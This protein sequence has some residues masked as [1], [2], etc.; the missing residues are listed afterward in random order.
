MKRSLFLLFLLFTISCDKVLLGDE[1]QVISL[2][3][4]LK[5]PPAL[6][7]DWEVSTLAAQSIDS[8]PIQNLIRFIQN[9]PR[10]I[11]SLL[12]FR[13]NKLVSESYFYGWHRERLHASRSASKSFI[14]TLVGI[15]IDQGHI[16][17]V[18]QKVFD[19]FPEYANLNN[20]QKSSI[21]IRHLLTMTAGLQWD[22]RNYLSD[23]PRNDETAFEKSSDRLGYI[24]GKAVVNTPGQR[25]EYNSGWPV[26]EAAIIKKSTG[27]DAEVFA[28]ENFF[29]PLNITNY[30]WRKNADDGH[31]TAIG[32]I[33]L[34]PRD[35]GKLGQLFLDNGKWKGRQIV[36]AQWVADATATVTG[37]ESNATG[38]GYHWWTATYTVDGNPVRTFRAQGSGGQ[39]IFVVPDLN[40][41]VV[42]TGGNYPPLN[43]G[44]PFNMMTNVILPAMF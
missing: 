23:D 11:H 30:Y 13:N 12:I 43:Q 36:S 26:V 31:I 41:V 27:E 16:S 17:D 14:S 44:G 42:F 34:R 25:F 32:P 6:N 22:E 20:A 33:L 21:E 40:A 38:Y 37:N 10:N 18:N 24:L 29:T 5:A 1:D 28:R 4:N 8:V 15:A 35:M 19:Y 39:Y 3:E 2:E 9:D 7:D